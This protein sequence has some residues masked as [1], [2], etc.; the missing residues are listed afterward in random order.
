MSVKVIA[1]LNPFSAERQEYD[2]EPCRIKDIQKKI[3]ASG[4]VDT[5]WRIMVNDEIISDYELTVNDGDRIYI[6]VIPEGGST[7]DT[8][9]GM[10]WAGAAMIVA[11]AILT[12]T[13][14][15][16]AFG[17]AL[18][19]AGVGCVA[20]GISLYN[21]DIPDMDNGRDSPE[22]DP[23]LRGSRNQM[24]ER[25]YIPALFGRRRIYSDLAT[26]YYTWVEDG[27]QYLYQLFCCG[28][29]DQQIDTS[30]IKIADTLLSE[31][32]ST[33]DINRVLS[34]RDELLEMKISYGENST[35]I[36]TKCVHESQ[37]NSILNH[38]TEDGVDA[39]LIETTV[40][41]TEEIHVDIFFPNGLGQ[42]SDDGEVV[43]AYV[44]VIA[45]YK[46][47]DEP[48]SQYLPLG[49]FFGLGDRLVQNQLKTFRYS[50]H[51]TGL[52]PGKYTVKITRLT[53]DST[54]SK[55]IDKCYVGSIRSIKN[56]NPISEEKSKLLTLIGLKIRVSEK[57]NGIV[58]QLNFESQ[59]ILP[60]P[61]GSG[62]SSMD[63]TRTKASSNPASCAIWAMQGTFS[64][65][66]IDSS[67]IDWRAFARLYKFCEEHG[68]ECNAY[69]TESMTIQQLLSAIAST[70]RAEIFRVNGVVT[71]VQDVER[72]S[73]V[74][75]FTPRN[76]W[77]YE[78]TISF[79]EI[80]DAMTVSFDNRE[81]GY[82]SDELMIY[83]T[84]NFE[85][86][87]EP[88]EITDIRTWGV[89]DKDQA[90]KLAIYKYA[91]TKNRPIV[92]TFK[93]DIEYMLCTKGDWIKY[94]G[95]VALVGI[96]Q[97]RITSVQRDSQGNVISFETDEIIPMEDGRD[98]AV[99]VRLA[100]S[101][102]VLLNVMT[103][104]GSSPQI[105]L[106]SP[107]A[108]NLGEQDLFAFGQLDS[109]TVDLI[110]TD[111]SCEENLTATITAV[112]YAPEIFSIDEPDFVL[113]DFKT[114]LSDYSGAIDK[115]EINQNG[116]RTYYT[117]SDLEEKPETPEG[118]G[119]G[120]NW[121]RIQTN[122][123]KWVSQKIS[124]D[125]HSG[126]WSAPSRTGEAA[127]LFAEDTK[128]EFERLLVEAQLKGS[129]LYSVVID[130]PVIK[131]LDDSSYS[132]PE[133][134]CTS[135]KTE[136]SDEGMETQTPFLTNWKITVNN[137]F[138]ALYEGKSNIRLNIAELMED[139][140]NK[141]A[142]SEF[143][144]RNIRILCTSIN[145]E[146]IIWDDE[147]IPVLS[148]QAGYVFDLTNEAQVYECYSSM[149]GKDYPNGWI[150][151]QKS[152]RTRAIV[153]EGLQALEYG[154][155]WS[156]GILTS[157][158][159]F[160]MTLDPD[161]SSGELVITALEGAD[162]AVDGVI[163][164]P[165][166]IKSSKNIEHRIGYVNAQ[167]E[168]IYI[169]YEE[170]GV[171]AEIGYLTPRED[172]GTITMHFRYQKLTDVAARL[173]QSENFI[174]DISM[175]SRVT[176]AEKRYLKTVMRQIK[177]EYDSYTASFSK[178]SSYASYK[179]AYTSLVEYIT[180][181]LADTSSTTSIDRNTFNARFD[182][183]YKA[184]SRL[185]RDVYSNPTY[186][187]RLKSASD[188]PSS[189]KKGDYFLCDFGSQT[190]IRGCTYKWTGE[191]WKPSF[192]MDESV[193]DALAIVQESTDES[194]PVVQLCKRLVAMQVI[195]DAL[196]AKTVY[197]QDMVSVGDSIAA[198]QE[199]ADD[200]KKNAG[201]ATEK[202]QKG[203]D[204][205]L[206]AYNKA[207]TAEEKADA[208]TKLIEAINEILESN[209]V[210]R[211]STIIVDGYLR[212]GLIDVE[213]LVAKRVKSANANYDT[214]DELVKQ[215]SFN[216]F[217]FD[218]RDGKGLSYASD[219]Y[220]NNLNSLNLKVR[221]M[222]YTAHVPNY[223]FTGGATGQFGSV[224]QINWYDL[225]DKCKTLHHL[226][227]I[228]T[229]DIGSVIGLDGIYKCFGTITF[230]TSVTE[231]GKPIN[232]VT[233][234]LECIRVCLDMTPY[235]YDGA[236]KIDGY[237]STGR[238]FYG[239]SPFSNNPYFD[240]DWLRMYVEGAWLSYEYKFNDDAYGVNALSVKAI[241]L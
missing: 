144:F 99:R 236:Y 167:G 152:V 134:N 102:S 181:I 209:G 219:F 108:V 223:F 163:D 179:S 232:F 52:T 36:V 140:K 207:K 215:A 156:Y 126:S 4:A 199:A 168:E 197:A 125:I 217:K 119:T 86:I 97:G 54:E 240:R 238:Y 147:F 118:D 96:K 45:L 81:V 79:A 120:G 112:N 213:T 153:Y 39:S 12:F 191:S 3:D 203:V 19:G 190:Y 146:S 101:S 235:G 222:G 160:S 158:P 46:K 100:D 77:D 21:I 10:S 56:Q 221:Q 131:K 142:L 60:V 98:Y 212:T 132:P 7:K 66:T 139:I 220:T 68:Y 114:N 93:C 229:K 116:W 175:D 230:A 15:G 89:T 121:H 105:R 82:A 151:T 17:V 150:K 9:K 169:G 227:T 216:G 165:V 31:F 241:I 69:L 224:S 26:Q 188:I 145:N 177:A 161:S 57:L 11:G 13:G 157:P 226:D 186:A 154:K 214:V 85:R 41:D 35:P 80:P 138:V 53:A 231:D 8:G 76:S 117:F 27:K 174:R 84:P 32:S 34:G 88:K 23:S 202:A 124:K 204:D 6:K 67:Q 173:A 205:A 201:T 28:Q 225:F 228:P 198:V 200:A 148:S 180:P 122:Q 22:Q 189:P 141:Y 133:V 185:D 91:V 239:I 87:T 24:R 92:A 113:P 128:A 183:Y 49:H 110:I 25:G 162:M 115:G 74:Q 194:I 109:E 38:E 135:C 107:Q 103:S 18:I 155:D 83:N 170:N 62:N 193:F 90:K 172:S 106:S 29:K 75:L 48:D 1:Q 95:D 43:H 37:H 127:I 94:A 182:A 171:S 59:S 184:L 63:W 208:Q 42:Y 61:H 130:T 2:F 58:E 14:Y 5:G 70:C 50:I 73:F 33:G 211:E 178:E 206:T 143:E 44:D 136:F 187:G 192:D 176:P 20:G 129:P 218:D 55:V 210:T 51:K 196:V 166:F 47:E 195:T 104:A 149:D 64:Q 164:I 65:Q 123:S 30:T 72:E 71:V 40:A 234:G 159:G 233:E 137:E 16:S 237:T 78:E 111:I